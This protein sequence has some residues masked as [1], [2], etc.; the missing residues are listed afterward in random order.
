MLEII[1]ATSS[2]SVND[3]GRAKTFYGETLGLDV[4]PATPDGRGP[5]WL[6][7]QGERTVLVYPKAD[8]LPASF[9]VLNFTVADIGEAVD[10]LDS[11][12]ITIE[13]YQ[14]YPTDDRGI[15]H[16]PDRSIAWFKD[17]AANVLSVMQ[18]QSD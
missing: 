5:F 7:F 17:P 13:R 16:G 8:H 3:I 10:R 12:G 2:F 1:E 18:V 15:V 6:R 11:Q 4:A 9:T 14:D